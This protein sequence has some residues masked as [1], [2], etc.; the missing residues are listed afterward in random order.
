MEM[1]IHFTKD[2]VQEILKEYYLSKAGIFN[3]IEP[4]IICDNQDKVQDE[5]V[6]ISNEDGWITNTQK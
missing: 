2:E 4:E 1:K 5:F 3:R 6:E